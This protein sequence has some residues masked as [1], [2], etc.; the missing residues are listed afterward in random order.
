MTKRALIPKATLAVLAAQSRADNVIVT[1]TFPDGT[2]V[3]VGPATPAKFDPF[4]HVDMK[5]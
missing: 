4:D 5:A 3:E 1:V 2:K